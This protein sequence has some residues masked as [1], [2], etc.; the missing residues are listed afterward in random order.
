M[1]IP[2]YLIPIR[3][4]RRSQTLRERLFPPRQTQERRRNL[5]TRRCTTP[6]LIRHPCVILRASRRRLSRL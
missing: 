3:R 1:A 6:Y 4:S 5:L 2:R